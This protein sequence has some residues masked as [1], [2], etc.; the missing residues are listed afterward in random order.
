MSFWH[1][2]EL[3]FDLVTFFAIAATFVIAGGVKGVIGLGLPTIS[4][5]L[6]I[7]VLDLTTAMALL[8]APSFVTNVYQASSGGLAGVILRRIWPFLL[9]ATATVWLGATALTRVDLGVLT[10]LLGL[11]LVAYGGLNLAGIR[12][13]IPGH[14]EGWTGPIFGAAN[15]ILTGMT[16]SFVVPGVM[17]L[18]GIGLS[19][20]MLVQAMGMLFTVSTVALAFALGTNALLSAEL[21]IVSLFAVIPSLTGMWAGQYV[22]G[23]LSETQFRSA[24]FIAIVL[25]GVFILVGAVIPF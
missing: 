23:S 3:M 19:R 25:L 8:I 1:I 7:V 12:L 14:I 10:T 17:Y 5:G 13:T 4:L 18:R 15:G 20:D 9:M 2:L 21:G 22:W 16:G 11:L 6:L 24:L